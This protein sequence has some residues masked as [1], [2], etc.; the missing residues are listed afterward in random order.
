MLRGPS[1]STACR[2]RRRLF[3]RDRKCRCRAAG[4]GKPIS[5]RDR[6][7]AR[8]HAHAAHPRDEWRR[9][10]D[11][12]EG[13]VFLVLQRH[14]DG[15]AERVRPGRAVLGQQRS[16]PRPSRPPR[17]RRAAWPA[18]RAAGC[19]PPRP[20]RA[21]CSRATARR[22]HH[23]DL[24]LARRIG[25]GDPVIDAAPAQRL[26]QVARAVRGEDHHRAFGRAQR[27]ALGDRDR[28]VGEEFEQ[29]RLELVIG[30]V[31]FV[32]QQHGRIRRGAAPR[33]SAARSGSRRA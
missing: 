1:S 10:A 22:A 33:A 12:D 15:A 5:G 19:R 17:R 28:E 26:V 11:A 30:A 27:A 14:A 2:K 29:E 21:P 25:I 24:G 32:D 20:R 13:E 23:D 8:C 7:R 16:R 31:D 9:A 4:R 18:A 6:A 3:R